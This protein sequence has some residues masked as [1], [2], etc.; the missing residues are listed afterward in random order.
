MAEPDTYLEHLER[1][2]IKYDSYQTIAASIAM[3][4]DAMVESTKILADAAKFAARTY[5]QVETEKLR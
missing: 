2:M 4:S 3:I 1:R 5:K